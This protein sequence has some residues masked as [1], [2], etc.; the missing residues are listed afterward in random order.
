VPG[1]SAVDGVRTEQ[2]FEFPPVA[3]I[4]GPLT[5][6]VPSIAILAPLDTS[7]ELDLGD[8]PGP[9]ASYSLDASIEVLGH[10]IPFDHAEIDSQLQLH[11][12]SA[13]V[14]LGEGLLFRWLQAGLPEGWSSPVGPGNK[15][16]FETRRQHLWFPME[17]NDG[18]FTTGV[19]SIP[20]YTAV[21]YLPGPFDMT[22]EGP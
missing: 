4:S 18:R 17:R 12:Y 6:H 22:F 1:E 9:G 3:S 19:I 7:I 13:P 10:S 2:L 11:L 14:E 5:L 8:Q 20:L 16:D 21:L 15:Y